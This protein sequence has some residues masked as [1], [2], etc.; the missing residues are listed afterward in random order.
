MDLNTFKP[1]GIKLKC[2]SKLMM[3]MKI[4]TYKIRNLREKPLKYNGDGGL[5]LRHHQ[6]H[7][8]F[9]VRSGPEE[10]A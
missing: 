10:E 7:S 4:K 1:N 6:K 5:V 8:S 2:T 3:K 9:M